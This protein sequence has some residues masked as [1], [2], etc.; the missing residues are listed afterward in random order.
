MGSDPQA[1]VD[2]ELRLRGIEGLRVA[3]ASVMPSLP[4]G[5][6]N[7]PTVMIA[8]RAAESDRRLSQRC[9]AAAKGPPLG[10]FARS[11]ATLVVSDLA[12]G[13]SLQVPPPVTQ[14]SVHCRGTHDL[15]VR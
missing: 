11:E 14:Q 10:V 7:W 15:L 1:V 6:T 2:P 12:L 3:D 4:S 13:N 9:T 8:E 5:H